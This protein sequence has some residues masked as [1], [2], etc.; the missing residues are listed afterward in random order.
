VRKIVHRA[1]LARHQLRRNVM[2]TSLYLCEHHLP[3]VYSGVAH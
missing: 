2:G 3:N 1:P